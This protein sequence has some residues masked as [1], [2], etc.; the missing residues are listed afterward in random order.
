MSC[1]SP[2]AHH[3]SRGFD[4]VLTRDDDDPL[5]DGCAISP[6]DDLIIPSVQTDRVDFDEDF[7]RG[8]QSG[9]LDR[10]Q[11]ETVRRAL[12]IEFVLLHR[13]RRHTLLRGIE[14]ESGLEKDSVVRRMRLCAICGATCCDP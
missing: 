7:G 4:T 5:S 1:F 13:V 11:A 2:A 3:R 12:F 14:S 9:L 10:L 8:S 6:I